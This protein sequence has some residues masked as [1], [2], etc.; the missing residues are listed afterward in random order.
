MG[1][2]GGPCAS[3]LGR[4][5]KETRCTFY[6]HEVP[7]VVRTRGREAAL[8]AAGRRGTEVGFNGDRLPVQEEETVLETDGAGG[9]PPH[10]LAVLSAVKRLTGQRVHISLQSN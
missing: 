6:S 4:S 8:L 3:E 10:S 9:G 1:G 7:R 5:P 2:S